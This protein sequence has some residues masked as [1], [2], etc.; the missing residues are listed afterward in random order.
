VG[1]ALG[2]ISS[3]VGEGMLQDLGVKNYKQQNIRLFNFVND[4]PM[5]EVITSAP[6]Y[7]EFVKTG[8]PCRNLIVR[9]SDVKKRY[10]K[11]KFDKE[12]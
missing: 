1:V 6:C 2:I 4:I 5:M 7:R 3:Y 12:A 11:A 10:A 9:T 8:E